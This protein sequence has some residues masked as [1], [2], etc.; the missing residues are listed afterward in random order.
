MISHDKDE[1]TSIVISSYYTVHPDDRQ[2]FIDAVVPHLAPSAQNPGSVYYVFAQ[3]LSDPNTFHLS[4]GWRNQ[5]ALDI[6]NASAPF[7][8]ALREVMTGVRIV[9]RQGQRYEIAA[10]GAGDP[11]SVATG[12]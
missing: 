2:K 1:P 6:H 3:D 8:T 11:P 7:Q 12:E 10:Q 9:G 5:E 4:E